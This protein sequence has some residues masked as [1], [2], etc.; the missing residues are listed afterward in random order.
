MCPGLKVTNLL[1]EGNG[2][3]SMINIP[4]SLLDIRKKLLET[5]TA[6][7]DRQ[8]GMKKTQDDS[9]SRKESFPGQLGSRP[10]ISIDGLRLV[11][12]V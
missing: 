8:K 1:A 9:N 11:V 4:H 6:R 2:M 10:T 12:G 7:P 5:L 3:V